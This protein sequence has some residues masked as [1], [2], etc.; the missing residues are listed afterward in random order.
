MANW[1]IAGVQLDCRL[2]DRA[3]NLVAIRG[4]LQQAAAEGAR[5]VVFPECIL[6]G[7]AYESKEEAWPH[8]EPIPGP[9]TAAV[10]D[11]CRRHGVWACFG[12]LEREEATG[13]LF[14]AC[15]LLGP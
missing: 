7:Y 1:K 13:H 10:G 15:A 11:D 12:M 4:R 6:S 2:G 14:N 8:S 3:G 5:L 9:A